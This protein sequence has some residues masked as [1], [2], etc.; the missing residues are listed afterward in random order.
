MISIKSKLLIIIYFGQ[1]FIDGLYKEYKKKK[2]TNIHELQEF[3][4][5]Y[6]KYYYW[7]R[8]EF[9]IHIGHFPDSVE[10]LEKI[11]AYR[12]VK[13]NLERITEYINDKLKL[14]F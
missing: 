9:E 3:I 7:T 10:E 6:F 2:I 13:M 1:N 12:Q 11:D 5:S 4:N 14:N 8:C